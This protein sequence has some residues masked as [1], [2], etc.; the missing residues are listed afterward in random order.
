MVAS[1][2]EKH[3]LERDLDTALS[4]LRTSVNTSQ[5]DTAGRIIIDHA[6]KVAVSAH[7]G[8]QR[9]EGDPY[10]IH[11]VRVATDYL[12]RWPKRPAQ[13]AATAVLH[14]V[15]E[16][17]EITE[18]DLQETFGRTVASGVDALTKNKQ[19]P[20]DKMRRKYRKRLNDLSKPLLQI[21]IVDRIDNL[22][23]CFLNPDEKKVVRYVQ[24]SK[25]HYLPLAQK[26]DDTLHADMKHVL[27][28]LT[29]RFSM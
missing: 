29:E 11:P 25:K 16:D 28:A 19:L 27:N 12:Q 17:S 2:P 13:Y 14:D 22:R 3:Q 5:I 20:E 15:S 26:A 24:H 7:E 8:Q 4:N 10:I 1:I 9:G 18:D 21:K 6:V 23:S